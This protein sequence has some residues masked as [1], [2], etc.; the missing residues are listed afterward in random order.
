[1]E[2][3]AIVVSGG[4]TKLEDTSTWKEFINQLEKELDEIP[5]VQRQDSVHVWSDE[6]DSNAIVSKFK[7]S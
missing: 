6:I 2:K 4:G 7:K 5:V 3:K 1:M